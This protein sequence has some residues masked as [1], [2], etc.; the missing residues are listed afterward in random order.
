[1]TWEYGKSGPDT[2]RC[3]ACGRNMEPTAVEPEWRHVGGRPDRREFYCRAGYGHRA[4]EAR[5]EVA[6]SYNRGE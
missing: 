1:M 6:A 4:D 3:A 2:I 5:E